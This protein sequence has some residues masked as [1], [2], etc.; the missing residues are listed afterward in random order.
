M[1][2]SLAYLD[3]GMVS[4]SDKQQ[5]PRSFPLC[6][7][8]RE[9]Q[10]ALPP[11]RIA[12][13]MY[14]H[15]VANI[16]VVHALRRNENELPPDRSPRSLDHQPHTLRPVDAVHEDVE[17]IQ[18]PDRRAHRFPDA[19]KQTNSREG[20]LATRESLRFATDAVIL[21][22][23]LREIRL[24]RDVELFVL[25]VHDNIAA[26]IALAEQVA[27]VDARTHSDQAPEMLPS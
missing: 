8:L 1:H 2:K 11:L 3:V 14:L 26:E 25:V 27:E 17:F 16:H 21:I 13:L 20:L 7:G 9:R 12:H 24:D 23:L 19:E 22:G 18:A 4:C 10:H 5:P 6:L 15:V